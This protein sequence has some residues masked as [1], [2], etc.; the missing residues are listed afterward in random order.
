VLEDGT[1]KIMDFG[2]AKSLLAETS[3]TRAGVALGTAGYL[4]PS[5]SPAGRSTPART[6]SRL[7]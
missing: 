3:L 2:I 4:S 6:S 5:S 1:V 7:A